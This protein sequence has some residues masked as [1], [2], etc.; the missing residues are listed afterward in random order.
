MCNFRKYLI[1]ILWIQNLVR[2]LKVEIARALW[3]K[4]DNA[5]TIRE[6][7]SFLIVLSPNSNSTQAHHQ[8]SIKRKFTDVFV[9]YFRRTE[10]LKLQNGCNNVTF[11]VHR[12]RT[13]RGQSLVCFLV[14]AGRLTN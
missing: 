13:K 3:G 14:K 9:P 5:S 7:W 4:R 2:S 1:Q 8:L 12:E 11:C 10:N 6:L